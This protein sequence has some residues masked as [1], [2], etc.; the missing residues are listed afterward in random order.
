[1]STMCCQSIL[2]KRAVKGKR[3]ATAVNA[4]KHVCLLVNFSSRN[5]FST[6][7]TP[8]NGLQSFI[9]KPS[10]LPAQ[11]D[12][13]RPYNN[14]RYTMT[15]V[16]SSGLAVEKRWEMTNLV[17]I[18]TIF[19]APRGRAKQ[20]ARSLAPLQKTSPAWLL[21]YPVHEGAQLA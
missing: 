1:M 19:G 6:L 17:D 7:A 10:P 21:V 9:L 12:M 13:F 15:S 4:S 3:S 16:H 5:A 18:C 11:C 20:R 8:R 14:H 2:K